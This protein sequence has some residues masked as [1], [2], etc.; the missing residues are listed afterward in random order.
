MYWI[1]LQWQ[2]ERRRRTLPPPEVLGWW[3]LQFTPRVAW[4]DEALLLEVVGQR[5][6]VGRAARL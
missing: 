3:A 1:A 2:P 4:L 6:A 5:A